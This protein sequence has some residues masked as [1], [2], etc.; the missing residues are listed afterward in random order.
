MKNKVVQFVSTKEI[1]RF[2]SKND[3]TILRDI[4][5]CIYDEVAMG[6]P[7]KEAEAYEV[8]RFNS[9]LRKLGDLISA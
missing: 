3:S 6:T 8:E 5:E 4:Y 2:I 9:E 1:K 7:V